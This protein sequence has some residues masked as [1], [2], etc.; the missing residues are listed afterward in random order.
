MEEQKPG[1]KTTEFW[2]TLSPIL[3]SFMEGKNF[4]EEQ[5]KYMIIAGA[6]LGGLYI[7]SLTI[8]KCKQRDNNADNS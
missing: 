5:S 2:V 8:G 6:I 7:V 1:I 4:N 3:I